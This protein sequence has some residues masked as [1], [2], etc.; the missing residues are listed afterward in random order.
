MVKGQLEDMATRAIT[1]Q[2]V[3]QPPGK[4]EDDPDVK[5]Q[6][7]L[8]FV[9]NIVKLREL[10]K[11]GQVPAP[12]PPAPPGV[13]KQMAE[14]FTAIAQTLQSLVVAE[15]E[16]RGKAESAQTDIAQKYFT[17]VAEYA[18]SLMSQAQ[19]PP[20]VP[21]TQS[22]LE[23]FTRWQGI[24]EGQVNKVIQASQ[25]TGPPAGLGTQDVDLK[26]LDHQQQL[27]MLQAQQIHE[28]A[29]ENL[30]L[31]MAQFNFDQVKWQK[32]EDKKTDWW[33]DLMTAVG[34]AVRSGVQ[35]GQAGGQSSPSPIGQTPA[36][37][38]VFGCQTPGCEQKFPVYP[39]SK[40]FSC[41]KCGTQ[42]KVSEGETEAPEVTAD[43]IPI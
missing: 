14:M 3:G 28:I 33:G 5:L 19:H 21:T 37:M 29:L 9:T 41:P 40:F 18:K 22:E 39:G 32:Q 8:D 35:A 12:A 23:V 17:T 34:G 36:G 20:N 16:A 30:K 1:G 43:E 26:R 31:Q 42:Y 38:P 11:V 7:T 15:R 6:K 10:E 24:I 2:G 25:A 13:D 4:K 27:A